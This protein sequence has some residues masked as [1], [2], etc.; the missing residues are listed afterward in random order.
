MTL[1]AATGFILCSRLHK[2]SAAKRHL[3]A[4]ATLMALIAFPVAMAFLPALPLPILPAI[5]SSTP[6]PIDAPPAV[7]GEVGSGAVLSR[8]ADV[9]SEDHGAPIPRE[10]SRRSLSDYVMLTSLA[11][12]AALLLHVLVSFSAA[13]FAVRRARRIDDA[14]LKRELESA[15][16]RLG[17]SRP[18]SLRECP[19]VTIP[20]VWGFVRP[21]LLLPVEA[22]RWD[23]ERIRVV[24]LHEIAHVARHDGVCLLLTRIATSVF[25]F[26]PL[27]WK[28]ARVVRRECERCCDDLV[29]AAGERAT[30][31]AAHLLA[32]VRS[33]TRPDRF[34]DI[35]PALAQE[36][37]LESRL[38]SILR[39]GQP[40]ESIS[41]SGLVITIGLASLLL[42]A[43]TVVQVVAAP[44]SENE[45]WAQVKKANRE[46]RQHA[47]EVEAA[48]EATS[49]GGANL[50][51]PNPGPITP[52]PDATSHE[53]STYSVE[54]TATAEVPAMPVEPSVPRVP[55]VSVAVSPVYSMAGSRH[56]SYDSND[57]GIELMRDGQYSRAITAF[58]EEIRQTGSTNARYN[59]ACAYALKGDKKLAFDALQKAIENGFD[60]T[61]HM[62]E[63]EDL[64]SLQG[65]PHFYELVRLARD[66]QLYSSGHFGGMNDEKDWSGLLPRLERITREHPGIGR[67]WAN[68]GFARLEAGD[69]KRG[70]VAYQK[71]L[72]LGYEK[73]TTLYNLACCAARSGD[74]DGA[75]KYLDRADQAG[76]EIGE[77]MGSDSDLDALR[78]D[79]RYGAMLKRWDEKMAKE[80]RGKQSTETKQ[81]TD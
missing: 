73:P 52:C 38:V 30:D 49:E 2:A 64:R 55:M 43:T 15:C 69:P 58:E 67:A 4:M 71:A 11:V 23:R 39:S 26:H 17:V 81:K 76:F 9:L 33:M 56:R 19:N 35:A 74:I 18:V 61:H 57:S 54:V 66:L 31:Y 1:I 41:R 10:S 3:A 75:F 70:V 53:A 29:L 12:S 65:D 7:Q 62:T 24:F 78:G 36:S 63:D 45:I 60:N 47:R 46:A 13:A 51:V 14:D 37:N 77:Y 16:R 27:V 44:E 5:P 40:R 25:W 72:D 21:V 50:N 28:L 48:L 80:H 20:A 59:L 6:L 79:A 22:R 8:H 42:A 68:L 32:M 34:V